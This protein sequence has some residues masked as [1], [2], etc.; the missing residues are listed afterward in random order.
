VDIA[1][2]REIRNACIKHAQD[3]LNYA[4]QIEGN[5]PHIAYHLATVAL[6][7][8]GKSFLV[9]GLPEDE[10][11]QPTPLIDKHL[12]KLF[13]ALFAP[14][15]YERIERKHVEEARDFALRIHRTRLAGLYVDWRDG[16]VFDPKDVVNPEHA[17]GMISLVD[18]R[19]RM[20]ENVEIRELTDE[21]QQLI[22]WFSA[23]S[24]DPEK[25]PYIFGRE[26]LDKLSELREAKT[27]FV[28]LKRQFD[29]SERESREFIA[30]ELARSRPEGQERFAP[31]W[32]MRIRLRT[33]S[34]SIRQ[35][36]LNEWN[37]R[38][39]FL[40][41]SRAG[42]KELLV[43]CTLPKNILLDALWWVGWGQARSFTV[44]LNI[45]SMG[46]FWF[47][48]PEALS[49]YYVSI[50]DLENKRQVVVE[51]TPRLAIDFGHMTLDSE[52]LTRVGMVLAFLPGP[53][54]I[55]MH[56]SF[57][58]YLTALGY[59]GKNDVHMQVETNA[60]ME[61]FMA[62]RCATRQYGDWDGATDFRDTARRVTERVIPAENIGDNTTQGLIDLA[63]TIEKG[64]QPTK[65]ITLTEVMGMKLMSDAYI[66]SVFNQK[67]IERRRKESGN[68][69][70]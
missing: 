27:W 25:R 51:R 31:K 4:K 35:K 5:S 39:D 45:G 3:L 12:K 52:T 9:R 26:S 24:A 28:W 56:Q 37:Q 55:S 29:E 68:T 54:D 63:A 44:A 34:H 57:N 1:I 50:E 36:P 22:T 61:F 62:F 15:M 59:M 7:E 2:Q 48:I 32:Q 60:F 33:L 64:H 41:L 42:S 49:R 46:F 47:T 6:E 40:K 30:C 10:H 19:L 43:D 18:A 21:D 38:V 65:A 66:L 11:E 14:V 17:R 69:P 23:A 13:W 67:A 58:H 53:N 8:I 20:E 70:S 16:R